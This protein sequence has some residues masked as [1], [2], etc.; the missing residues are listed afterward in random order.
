MVKPTQLHDISTTL[1]PDVKS[2][3]RFE[4]KMYY[5]SCK[6]N[7]IMLK[8]IRK[9]RDRIGIGQQPVIIIKIRIF[10]LFGKKETTLKCCDTLFDEIDI[11]VKQWDILIIPW[12]KEEKVSCHI[13]W[14]VENL[15]F[16]S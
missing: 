16:E 14:N 10:S 8:K 15:K 7:D 12:E 6:K 1:K 2:K 11:Y 9:T 3:L 4:S 13:V 5:D